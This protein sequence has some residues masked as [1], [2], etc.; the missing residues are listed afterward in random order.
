MSMHNED[1]EGSW[2]FTEVLDNL[3]TLQIIKDQVRIEMQKQGL[4]FETSDDEEQSPQKQA[5]DDLF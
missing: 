3:M 1:P 4:S 2:Y 5:K